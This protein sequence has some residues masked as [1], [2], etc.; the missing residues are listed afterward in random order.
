MPCYQVNLVSLELK[1]ENEELIL[2][3]LGAMKL[4]PRKYG[5]S[6]STTIGTFNIDSQKV[7][8][9]ESQ[10]NTFN[11]FKKNYAIESIK[12]AAKKNRWTLKQKTVNKFVANKW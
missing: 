5:D 9:L 7:D 1:A 3:V 4:A 12:I 6:I 10:L 11:R 8:I 2:K